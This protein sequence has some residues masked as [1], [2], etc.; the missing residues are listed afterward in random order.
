MSGVYMDLFEAIMGR[1]S[2]RR[3]KS[4]PVSDGE[5]RRVLEAA[6]WAPSWANTQ[7]WEFIVV[8]N[9]EAKK[10]LSETLSKR[11]PATKAVEKAPVVIVACGRKEVSG[12]YKGKPV[13]EKGDWLMFDVALAVQNLCLAAYAMGLGTVIVGAFDEEKASEILEIPEDV[14][15]VA[16]IP[17][18]RPAG[19]HGAPPRRT[20]DEFTHYETYGNKQPK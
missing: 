18:G 13:T 3:F 10:A 4:D 2:V 8:R 15:I 19:E 16:M 9:P 17:L 6:R 5:V 12:Y 11:N 1:R 14:E 20:V 7:C